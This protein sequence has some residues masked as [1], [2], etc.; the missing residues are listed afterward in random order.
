MPIV[1]SWF[2]HQRPNPFYIPESPVY[3]DLPHNRMECIAGDFFQSV[4]S[5]ADAYTPRMVIHDWGDSEAIAILRGVRAAMP[6]SSRL[7]LIES[8]IPEGPDPS[9]FKFTDLAMMLIG[10]RERSAAEFRELY[11]STGFELEE[12]VPTPS[13]LN[14][15]IGRPHA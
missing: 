7:I 14:L 5:G 6:P 15:I 1:D 11:A 2:V 10:G 13:P 12:I 8:V 3:G 9:F 4:P